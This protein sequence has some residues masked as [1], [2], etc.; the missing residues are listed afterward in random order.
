MAGLVARL[1]HLKKRLIYGKQCVSR[2][3]YVGY[4]KDIGVR[5]GSGVYIVDPTRCELDLTRPFLLEIGND[6]IITDGVRV[7]THDFSYSVVA[8]QF[9]GSIH[10][11]CD[12]VTIGN[13][14]FLGSH[15]IILPGTKIG[16]NCIVGAGAVV[17]GLVSPNSVLAG[18]PARTICTTDE[19]RN[20]IAK[21]DLP[22]LQVLVSEYKKVHGTL[23]GYDQLDEFYPLFMGPNEVKKEYP[24]LYERLKMSAGDYEP[25]FSSFDDMMR[26]M[27]GGGEVDSSPS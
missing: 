15:A 19:Y 10:P 11:L 21:R 12:K 7:L 14:V 27:A 8:R 18:N 6:V 24:A 9:P 4:L 26:A 2:E 1:K 20:K 13:N 16:D 23:P 5:I 17:K 25:V 22:G 3:S